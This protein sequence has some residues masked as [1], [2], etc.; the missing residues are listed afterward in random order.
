MVSIPVCAVIIQWKRQQW[1]KSP[2]GVLVERSDE[3]LSHSRMKRRVSLVITELLCGLPKLLLKRCH[4][5]IHHL[6]C[7]LSFMLK[8]IATRRS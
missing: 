5:L 8:T 1:H 3:N 4:H 7:I 6:T 2:F